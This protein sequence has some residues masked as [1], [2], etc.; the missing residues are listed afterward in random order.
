L[1]KSRALL[2]FI[3]TVLLHPALSAQ[4][5]SLE[6][7]QNQVSEGDLESAKEALELF[8]VENPRDFEAKRL[9]RDI[10]SRIDAALAATLIEEALFYLEGGDFENAYLILEKAVRL[11]PNN[12]EAVVLFTNL[13]D[14][15]DV[16]ALSVREE[17]A[18][19]RAEENKTSTNNQ[20]TAGDQ[21]SRESN[22]DNTEVANTQN[23]EQSNRNNNELPDNQNNQASNTSVD[24]STVSDSQQSGFD[25]GPLMQGENRL[26]LAL[27]LTLLLAGTDS[28]QNLDTGLVQGGTGLGVNFSPGIM[29]NLLHLEVAYDLTLLTL[30]GDS[31]VAYT[32]NELFFR[33]AFDIRL[34]NLGEGRHLII[35]PRVG[36]NFFDLS[37]SQAAGIYYFKQLYSPTFGLGFS[38]PIL[39]H[40]ITAPWSL[41]LV[42]HFGFDY[43]SIPAGSETITLLDFEVLG[44]EYWIM[45][46]LSLSFSN[47]LSVNFSA[48]ASESFYRPSL[49][50]NYQLF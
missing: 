15:V 21:T 34:M 43:S 10:Q 12:D 25:F 44:L 20:N 26:G 9:Q 28:I 48:T 3:G 40:F 6:E 24:N 47:R 50:V 22:S 30:A 4:T 35:S 46:N 16:E 39:A 45:D 31:R 36:Y 2:V 11:D 27:P 23:Q 32:L 18:L 29:G 7:I 14:V 8:I 5:P 33:L 17:A 37:N 1:I 49:L 42:F 41:D 38:D 13:S 19:A